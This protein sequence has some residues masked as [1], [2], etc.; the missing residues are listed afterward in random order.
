MEVY[1]FISKLIA[2]LFSK[3][4]N[5]LFGNWYWFFSGF[6]YGVCRSALSIDFFK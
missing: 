5:Y 3:Y 2:L 4:W 1:F 6:K